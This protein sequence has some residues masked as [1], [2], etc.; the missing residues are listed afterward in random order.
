MLRGTDAVSVLCGHV[1]L[2]DS[3]AATGCDGAGRDSQ[4]GM[5][6]ADIPR[7]SVKGPVASHRRMGPRCLADGCSSFVGDPLHNGTQILG[8]Q[9]TQEH[10]RDTVL[11]IKD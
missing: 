1:P 7:P 3:C 6:V 4:I 11:A 2:T 8:K 9:R 10:G 5:T